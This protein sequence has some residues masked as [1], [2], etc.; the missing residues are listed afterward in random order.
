MIT[1]G[2]L[3]MVGA[4]QDLPDTPTEMGDFFTEQFFPGFAEVVTPGFV[5]FLKK[6]YDFQRAKAKQLGE[7]GFF[8]FT[9]N[10]FMSDPTGNEVTKY[11]Y[12]FPAGGAFTG[13]DGLEEFFGLKK[14]RLDL[15]QGMRRNILPITSDL[16]KTGTYINKALGSYEQQ[17]PER[18]FDAYK[19]G[20]QQKLYKFRQLQRTLDAYRSIFG[21]ELESELYKGLSQNYTRSLPF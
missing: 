7:E 12:S 19:K 18:V 11:G 20:Q 4:G 3:K 2:M 15:N 21:G 8:G 17:S 5:N 9:A 14:S 1:E 10:S 16:S 6:R 13:V